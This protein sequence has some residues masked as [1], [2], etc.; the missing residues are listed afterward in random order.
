MPARWTFLASP[1]LVAITAASAIILATSGC[2]I[3]CGATAEKL[4]ALRRGMS[5]D[6]ASEI[7]G[8]PGRL[9]TGLAPSSGGYSIVEWNG[10]SSLFKRTQLD[11]MGGELLSYTTENRGAL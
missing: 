11:F 5:Y 8:C 6:N 9:V 4:A 2:A 10:P 1:A 7:M 3:Q